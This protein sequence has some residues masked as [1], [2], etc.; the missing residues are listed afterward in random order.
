METIEMSY[1]ALIVDKIVH[2]ALRASKIFVA[3]Y[4]LCDGERFGFTLR[5]LASSLLQFSHLL[6]LLSTGINTRIRTC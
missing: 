1:I 6:T 4:I 5:L 3:L 2:Y